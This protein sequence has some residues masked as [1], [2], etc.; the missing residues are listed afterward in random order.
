MKKNLKYSEQVLEH[1]ALQIMDGRICYTL[2]P[3]PP[4]TNPRAH[5][6][7]FLMMPS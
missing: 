1:F 3:T 2:L 5:L 7:L 6:H 4:V